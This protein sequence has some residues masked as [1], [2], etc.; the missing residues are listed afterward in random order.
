MF[1]YVLIFCLLFLAGCGKKENTPPPKF[2]ISKIV[3]SSNRDGRYEIY[4]MD[5]DGTNQQK[6]ISGGNNRYP[7][8]SPEGNS[9]IFS[10]DKYS[11]RGYFEIY[12]SY[13]DGKNWG[14]VFSTLEK[15]AIYPVYSKLGVKIAFTLKEGENSDIY[16]ANNDGTTSS[17]KFSRGRQG[18]FSLYDTA[19]IF[20]DE[21]NQNSNIY[22]QII[23]SQVKTNLSASAQKNE[24]PHFS[25]D[26][27]YIFYSSNKDG[28]YEIYRMNPDGSEQ[29]RLTYNSAQDIS[30]NFCPSEGKVVFSSNREGQYEIYTMD[31][32]G[33]NLKQL[34][35]NLKDDIEPSW[36]CK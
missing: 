9:I 15:D 6:I 16:L 11:F 4:T 23:G 31:V 22:H 26:G 8:V 34:T 24:Y 14:K 3:F 25:P 36:W 1:K 17:F 27:K 32:D 30:P 19:L 35:G 7:N 5:K 33:E 18:D 29:V 12:T 10:S 2:T 21:E 28:N 13:I 20:V